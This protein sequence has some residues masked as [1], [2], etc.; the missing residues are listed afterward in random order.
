MFES[1]K[2]P[3]F[4][5]FFLALVGQM[6][7]QNIQMVVRAYLAFLLTDSYAILG[8]VALANA[9]PGLVLSLVGGAVAD[10]VPSRKLVMIIGQTANGLNTGAIG[11][12]L[13][14][15]MLTMEHL[16]IAAVVQ[17]ITMAL[18]M[19]SRQSIIP[20]LVPGPMLMNAVALNAATINGTRLFAPALGGIL[21]S[22]AGGAT[23]YFLMASLYGLACVFLAKVLEE[24]RKT[25][26]AGSVRGEV[27]VAFSNMW[28]GLRYIKADPIIGPLLLINVLIVLLAM[29]YMF[30]LAGFVQDVLNGDA[31]DVGNLLSI[32]GISALT[33]SLLVAQMQRKQRGVWFLAGSALQGVFLFIGFVFATNVL[34]MA[35]AMFFMGFG[36][37]ARQSLSNVLVQEYVQDAF[38]GRVMS[39]YMLQFSL[40]SLGTAIIGG[41]A[42]WLGPQTALGTTSMLL[43]VLCLGTLAFSKRLRNLQ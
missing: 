11:L 43:V 3:A 41:L 35:V 38:R 30:L 13:L 42:S 16:L 22:W 14:L 21:F 37:A 8:V 4:M 17:G 26:S 32:S 36:Q 33:G 7:S 18:M 20:S 40:A 1:L 31:A 5:Y 28:L 12:L 15:D 34:M 9:V 23:V 24:P 27:K 6:A 19:P 25:E 39:I 2:Y 29:P 10:R